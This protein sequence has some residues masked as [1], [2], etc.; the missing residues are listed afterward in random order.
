MVPPERD[1][2]CAEHSVCGNKQGIEEIVAK[3]AATSYRAG[4]R[5]W[6]KVRHTDT[7]DA[8][9]VGFMGPRLRPH[10]LALAVGDEGGPIRLSA[11]L[12]PVLAARMGSALTSST[13]AGDR[14]AQ[15]ETY[16]R[17]ET[18]RVVEVLAGSGRHGTRTVVRL[19]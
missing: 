14:R 13:V 2:T 19:R 15:R 11:R 4:R 5:K 7:V 3:P 8:L 9:V 17:V 10:H 16:T 18:D 6:V 12:E 1:T